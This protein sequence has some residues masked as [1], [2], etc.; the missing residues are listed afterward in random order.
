MAMRRN[1]LV[2]LI[3]IGLAGLTALAVPAP[4]QWEK[5]ASALAEQ[6][7]GILGPGQAQL[8]IRNLSSIPAGEV[9]AIRRL[10]EQDLKAHGVLVSGAESANAIRITLSESARERL[11]VAEIVEGNETRMAMVQVALESARVSAVE[12]RIILRKEKYI[13][14]SEPVLAVLETATALVLLE[15]EQIVFYG[16]SADG[17]K[18]LHRASVGT[19]GTLARDP[20]GALLGYSNGSSVEA[21]LPGVQCS[22]S[23]SPAP[24]SSDWKI[25]C[26]RG[27]DAWAIT[28]PPLQLTNSAEPVTNADVSV[29][30]IRAFYNASR[31]YFTGVLTPGPSPDLRP[32]YSLATVPRAGGRAALLVSGIDGKVQLVDNGAL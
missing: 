8:T 24:Q 6:I 10:L 28:Q 16:R 22:G 21:W 9:P 17:W 27:D 14:A 23:T 25:Q 32:F 31:N 2:V 11:W 20:R 4:S 19:P 29:M 3:A 30:P 15:P 7:A 12:E 13:G 18:E 5:P 1:W 26:R